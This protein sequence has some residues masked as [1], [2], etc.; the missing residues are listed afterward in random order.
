MLDEDF[1]NI[2]IVGK[3]I[4]VNNDSS[5]SIYTVGGKERY[6]GEFDDTVR[7]VIPRKDTIRKL[8][9]ATDTGIEQMTLR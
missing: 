5:L 9:L 4:Y 2:Q 8:Y 6:S 1:T 3:A 7:A